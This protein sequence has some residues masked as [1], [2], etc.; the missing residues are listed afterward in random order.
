MKVLFCICT[1]LISSISFSAHHKIIISD[2]SD[3]TNQLSPDQFTQINQIEIRFLKTHTVD[4][5]IAWLENNVDKLKKCE[6]I[7]FHLG[8]ITTKHLE[9]LLSLLDSTTATLKF[10]AMFLDDDQ[11]QLICRNANNRC[12]FVQ[13][14][15]SENGK[16]ILET[17]YDNIDFKQ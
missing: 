12:N 16:N 9:R 13:L 17:Y 4:K 2:N 3:E 14:T 11:I 15:T 10:S 6:E 5:A 7:S 1:I 8:T